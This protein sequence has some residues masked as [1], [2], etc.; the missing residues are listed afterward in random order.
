VADAARD[1][2][3]AGEAGD[4]ALAAALRDLDR[5]ELIRLLKSEMG[6][7]ARRLEFEKAASLRDRIEE[8]EAE[9][10]AAG[11]PG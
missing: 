4:D 7:A 10:A 9:D 2:E 6:K 8:I 1:E 3:D 5:R 11:R